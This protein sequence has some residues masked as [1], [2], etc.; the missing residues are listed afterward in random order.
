MKMIVFDGWETLLNLAVLAMIVVA[1]YE[2][3]R[4]KGAEE[5]IN[6]FAPRRQR[7]DETAGLKKGDRTASTHDE[8]QKQ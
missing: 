2:R 5:I 8:S 4:R 3:G 7:L 1:I 6:F